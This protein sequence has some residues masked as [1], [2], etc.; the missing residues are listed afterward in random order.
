[1]FEL[2]TRLQVL[3]GRCN[4]CFAFFALSL[5]LSLFLHSK[6][7]TTGAPPALDRYLQPAVSPVHV[8]TE[9]HRLGHRG[10]ETRDTTQTRHWPI[11]IRASI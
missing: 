9:R 1:M 8:H 11:Y 5:S 6:P 4:V 10:R 2:A 3:A 7:I